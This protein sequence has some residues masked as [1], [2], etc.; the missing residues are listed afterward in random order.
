MPRSFSVAKPREPEVVG[1]LLLAGLVRMI[2]PP[3][4]SHMVGSASFRGGHMRADLLLVDELTNAVR[5]DPAQLS[6]AH[7]DARGGWR[8]QAATAVSPGRW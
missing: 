2:T 3:I 5:L 7:D 1:I 4:A 6:R 8:R